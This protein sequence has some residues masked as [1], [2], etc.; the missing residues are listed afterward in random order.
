MW[1]FIMLLSVTDGCYIT[2][3]LMCVYYRGN[4]CGLSEIR[5]ISMSFVRSCVR[6]L[7]GMRCFHYIYRNDRV[8]ML[9]MRG[10]KVSVLPR[11]RSCMT[12]T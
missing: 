12:C 6:S 8:F 3:K 10:G 1:L 5:S 4:L 7:K 11:M 2:L 9:S